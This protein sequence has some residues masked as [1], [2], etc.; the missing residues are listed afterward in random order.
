MD[1]LIQSRVFSVSNV[2]TVMKGTDGWLYYTDTLD[3]Y[4]GTN[5]MNRRQV[6]NVANN[7]SLLQQ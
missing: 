5:L 4:L 3:D 1:A 2:D 7:L 6:F